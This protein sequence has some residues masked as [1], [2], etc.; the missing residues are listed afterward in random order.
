MRGTQRK[1]FRL[2]LT[3]VA[4]LLFASLPAPLLADE[5]P[6]AWLN[7]ALVAGEGQTVNFGDIATFKLQPG[8]H[9]LDKEGT[10]KLSE[11]VGN[12][13]SGNELGYIES[14]TETWG[15]YFDYEETG[16]IEDDE[17]TTIDADELLEQYKSGV[18]A[19]NEDL[20]PDQQLFID[21]WESE[22]HYDAAIKSLTWSLLAHDNDQ[23]KLTNY[24]IRILTRQGVIS[25]VMVTSPEQL[26]VHRETFQYE[27]LPLLTVNEGQRHQDYDPAVDKKA[28]YGLTGLIL[29]GAGIAVAKKV[30]LLAMIA[31][32]FKKFG[33]VIIGGIAVLV[34][35]FWGKI[36]RKKSDNPYANEN[37]ETIPADN[38]NPPAM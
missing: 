15:V 30:G 27:I 24:N 4:M 20:E 37:H 19:R 8:L 35:A 18:E 25:A 12:Y 33:I 3:A 22:P 32:G 36:F 26:P 14:A 10:Q 5:D 29:G 17:Q 16:Y 1:K 23:R 21:G 11:V 13:V 6:Y 2:M 34:K 31:L 38:T 28:E 7:D 9:Y